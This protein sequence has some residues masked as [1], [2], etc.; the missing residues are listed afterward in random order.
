MVKIKLYKEKIGDKL[1]DSFMIIILLISVFS[2]DFMVYLLLFN[3]NSLTEEQ[4]IFFRTI[5]TYFFTGFTA[6]STVC[7]INS[8]KNIWKKKKLK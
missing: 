3:S 5:L 7:I 1:F 8:F 6:V 4:F 2:F